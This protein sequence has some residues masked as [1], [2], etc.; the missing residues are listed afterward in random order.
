MELISK[1]HE[2]RADFEQQFYTLTKDETILP[3]SAGSHKVNYFKG[4]CSGEG[5]TNYRNI[6]ATVE[7][8]KQVPKLY[9]R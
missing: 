6:N 9:G 3:G 8:F 1:W 2:I 4:H 5:G 7:S